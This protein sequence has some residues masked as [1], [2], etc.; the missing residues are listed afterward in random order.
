VY[1]I[2][3]FALYYIRDVLK[4][5]NPVQQ[6]GDLL[7]ALTAALVVLAVIGG[8]L[9]DRFGAKRVLYAAGALAAVGY[10]LLRLAQTP[11]MLIAYGSVIGAGIGLFLTASWALANKL[12]P[13][14]EAGKYL[15]LTNLAT[16]GAGALARLEGPLVD[17][18][19]AARPGLWFGYTGL[20]AFGTVCALLSMVLLTR[21][22]LPERGK[23]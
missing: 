13:S 1:G 15:G 16:A 9:S 2:Q 17:V 3:A 4:A 20:F 11:A 19:N 10:M 14:Q 18:F 21:V 12:A 6:T 5:E 23:G 7:A 8:W 22:P